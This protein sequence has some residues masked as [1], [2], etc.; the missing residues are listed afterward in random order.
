MASTSLTERRL[1]NDSHNDNE[2]RLCRYEN[3]N[4]NQ[5]KTK[6]VKRFVRK[7]IMNKSRKYISPTTMVVWYYMDE[8]LAQTIDIPVGSPGQKDDDDSELVKAWDDDFGGA[9][10]EDIQVSGTSDVWDKAW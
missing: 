3:K 5:V 9:W 10:D 1:L 4:K 6:K 2:T 8:E 7:K